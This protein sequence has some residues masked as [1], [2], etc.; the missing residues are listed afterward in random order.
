[1][2]L[3]YYEGHLPIL[4]TSDIELIDEIFYK[5]FSHFAARK[6]IR[7]ASKV[8]VSKIN[9]HTIRVNLFRD[10]LSK[11]PMMA[12][13]RTCFWHPRLVGNVFETLLTRRFRP[14]S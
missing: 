11:S 7:L 14:P 1:M 5:K 9:K 13:T 2:F 4:V 8:F 12:P 3:S 10:I 6:V